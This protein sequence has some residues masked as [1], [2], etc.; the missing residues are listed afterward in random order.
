MILIK[1]VLSKKELKEFIKFP[2]SLY[3]NSKYWVPPII[4]E[5]I[6]VFNKLTNPVLQNADA[7]LFLAYK[8]EKIVG[9]VAA[10]TNWLEINDQGV[11]KMRFGWLDMIDDLEVTKALLLE[12]ETIGKTHKLDH[13][14]GPIGFSN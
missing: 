7:R 6:K 12:V 4:S 1:E 8:D 5:E 10:I 9:R 11:H 13:M 14:E 2:F 3:K